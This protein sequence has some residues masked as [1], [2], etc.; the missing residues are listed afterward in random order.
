MTNFWTIFKLLFSNAFK[1]N[2]SKGNG[3]RIALITV[4]AVL[5]CLMIVGFT[6][7]TAKL[8]PLMEKH[9][10]LTHAL[11]YAVFVTMFLVFLFGIVPTISYIFLSKD[12]EF[13]AYMP[14][15]QNTVFLAKLAIIYL[16]QLYLA[17]VFMLPI[18]I[19]T[20]VVL[21]FGIIFYLCMTL[22]LLALPAL[23]LLF[24]SILALPIM[25]VIAFLK[26]RG[27]FTSIA[28]VLVF[29]IVYALYF[30]LMNNLGKGG[31]ADQITDIDSLFV[32]FF[33]SVEGLLTLLG[34]LVSMIRVALGVQ[35][36]IFGQ[37]QSFW[38]S[39]VLNLGFFVIFFFVAFFV[40]L[41]LSGMIYYKGALA[42][43]ESIKGKSKLNQKDEIKTVFWTL[44]GKEF[45]EMIRTPAF[46]FSCLVSTVMAPIVTAML[47]VNLK[48]DKL[49]SL[50]DLGGLMILI[51][52]SVVTMLGAGFNV[53]A[54][55]AISREGD[56]FYHMKIIPVDY[57][58]QVKAK[59]YVYKIISLIS[60]VLSLTV[61][62]AFS[63]AVTFALLAFIFM[64]MYSFA[65]T[66][67]VALFDLSK[68]KLKW[69]TPNE[70][71]KRNLNVQLPSFINILV[72]VVIFGLA[73]S[74]VL[75]GALGLK[76]HNTV[77]EVV[78]WAIL[79]L[80]SA[81]LWIIFSYILKIKTDKFINRIEV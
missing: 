48:L 66:N 58:L 11:T 2:K 61:Y 46:A 18:I 60:I 70:V 65:F 68:P 4:I 74:W 55:T 9:N 17:A 49:N 51:P 41:K 73:S 80:I 42:Q 32:N 54:C 12:T 30:L 59:L 72:T 78:M 35:Q 45:K 56:K 44:V 43:L 10:L 71:I 33:S 5:S 36:T 69:T 29:G 39:T 77:I 79:Y 28:L 64:C 14:I 6:A 27:T 81:T 34:P 21:H 20:G 26:R 50:T 38:A 25:S 53:G 40:V 37:M 22:V 19:T 57:R 63:N 31:N 75:L 7:L 76:L 8:M 24:L 23:P 3:L 62:A 16:L 15:G 67:F 1:W 52:L 47:S 13:F